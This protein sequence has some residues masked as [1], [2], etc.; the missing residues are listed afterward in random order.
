M[1][2]HPATLLWCWLCAVLALQW[3]PWWWLLWLSLPLSVW[4]MLAAR[5]RYSQLLRRSRWLLL[6]ILILFAWATP[7]LALPGLA[8]QLGL[9]DTG[10]ELAATH[11]LRLVL[12]LMLLA[13]LLERLGVTALVAGLHGLLAPLGQH[14]RRSQ[15]ALRLML[16]LE[17]VEQGRQL[18]QQAEL[19]GWRYWLT[20]QPLM[21]A[22]PLTTIELPQTTL[23]PLARTL[24]AALM[25]VAVLAL[26]LLA[27]WS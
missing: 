18:Q 7:G 27:W 1:T 23:D 24:N 10:I 9:T 6:S 2:L 20:P 19:P 21:T 8:G 11:S 5:R 14:P 22:S 16:V 25:L 12:L 17:Y 13:L 4:V 3:L 26:A 15:L